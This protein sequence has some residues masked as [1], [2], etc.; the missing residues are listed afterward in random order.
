M[1]VTEIVAN[2]LKENGFDG[3]HSHP[4]KNFYGGCGC[5]IKDFRL[6]GC[7][8]DEKSDFCEPAY[9]HTKKDCKKCI[10]FDDCKPFEDGEKF[11]YCGKKN[12]H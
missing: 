12:A 4:E 9:K 7:P 11:M 1:T 3:L 2:F 6:R 8:L 10:L 5:S